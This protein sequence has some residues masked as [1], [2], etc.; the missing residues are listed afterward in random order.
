MIIL[1]VVA[2][3]KTPSICLDC[4]ENYVKTRSTQKRCKPC[5]KIAATSSYLTTYGTSLV[6]SGVPCGTVGAIGELIVAANLLKRG[7]S[8][9]RAVS[10]CSPSDL[11]AL[12]PD[13]TTVTLEVRTARRSLK[14]G[15][16][17]YAHMNLRSDITALTIP[18]ENEII[19]IAGSTRGEEVLKLTCF[20]NACPR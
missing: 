2:P 7:L 8:V 9:F 10:Q 11:I 5:R 19:Y 15:V 17:A 1:G 3:S 4:N 16:L 6:R 13:K 12:L 14:T 18:G 20:T